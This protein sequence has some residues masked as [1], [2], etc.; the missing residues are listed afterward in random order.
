[1]IIDHQ[2]YPTERAFQAVKRY[3]IGAGA[4]VDSLGQKQINNQTVLWSKYLKDWG[5][6]LKKKGHTWP[7]DAPFGLVL[8]FDTLGM[9]DAAF[10]GGGQHLPDSCNESFRQLSKEYLKST[11][12][13]FQ[14]AEN[15]WFYQCGSIRFKETVAVDVDN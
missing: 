11:P 5:E 2:E 8:Y 4:L 9:M 12:L 7:S 1:M 15:Q 3:Y 10:I 14:N 13:Q 6:H